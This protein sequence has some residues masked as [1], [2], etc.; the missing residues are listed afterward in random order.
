MQSFPPSDHQQAF[1]AALGNPTILVESFGKQL[2]AVRVDHILAES[3]SDVFR[4]DI[5]I[6][7]ACCNFAGLPTLFC[8]LDEEARS[9][10]TS[11]DSRR[12]NT[13]RFAKRWI[14]SA[15]PG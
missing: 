1:F 14:F 3:R 7:L 10:I 2:P 9:F 5:A 11:P 4:L 8:A 12:L 13:V 6:S 15:N